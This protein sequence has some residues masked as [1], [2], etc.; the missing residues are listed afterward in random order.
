LTMHD[1][2]PESTTIHTYKKFG[3]SQPIK[4][5]RSQRVMM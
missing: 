3:K 2:L 5:F 1:F 4:A